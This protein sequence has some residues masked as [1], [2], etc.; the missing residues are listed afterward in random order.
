MLQ[1]IQNMELVQLFNS[2]IENCY[3]SE[4]KLRYASTLMTITDKIKKSP[5]LQD[6]ISMLATDFEKLTLSKIRRMAH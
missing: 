5:E 1:R 4:S 3:I 2:N 6:I